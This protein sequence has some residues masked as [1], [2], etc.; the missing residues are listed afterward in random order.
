MNTTAASR[1]SFQRKLASVFLVLAVIASLMAVYAPVASASIDITIP[2]NTVVTRVRPGTEVP[3]ASVPSGDQE[4]LECAVTAESM[5]QDSVNR[6]NNLIV[7]SDGNSVVLEDVENAPG[8]V[9]HADGTLL[10]GSEITVTLVM[11]PDSRFSAGITVL[12]DCTPETTT[13]TTE[14]TTTTTEAT[15]TTTE[16]TTTTTEATTTTTLPVD[17]DSAS[18]TVTKTAGVES[19]EAPGEDVTFTVVIVNDSETASVTITSL[20]DD[21]YGVLAGDEDCQV[22]T[23][24]PPLASCSFDFVGFVGGEDGDEHHNTVTVNGEDESDNPVGDDDDATVD[25][26]GTEVLDVEVLPFTGIQTELLAAAG[27]F[28]LASGVLMLRVPARRE[29]S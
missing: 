27:L 28:L 16:A 8:A 2:I 26:L 3:L 21:V 20:E 15:T 17:V 22:G 9:I 11:G 6:N 24:L 7:A 23:A 25:V 10:L 29:E 18:I 19:V 13:T 1:S 4:G 14:A 5:N 12:I